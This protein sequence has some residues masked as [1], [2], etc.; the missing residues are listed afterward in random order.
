MMGLLGIATT[1]FL[2][3]LSGAMTPGPLTLVTMTRAARHGMKAGMMVCLGHGITEAVLVVLLGLG[4]ATILTR[5]WLVAVVSAAGAVA[6]AWM[7]F[8]VLNEARR[9]EL[10]E[11]NGSEN[12][13][14]RY[15]AGPVAAGIAATLGNPYWL[16]WW[17]TVGVSYVVLA[18]RFG[19]AGLTTFFGGHFMADVIT[20]GV[21]SWLI[22]RGRSFV[23]GDWYRRILVVL[24]LFLVGLA[25]YFGFSAWHF[26]Q[27]GLP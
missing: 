3:G 13:F 14:S 7:G 6:L 1:A 5:S 26:W 16:V 27:G 4:A 8:S 2:V 18:E 15:A 21:V 24:G 12:G 23:A 22:A 9:V 20:L 17:A 10:V 19:A 25:I 11:A